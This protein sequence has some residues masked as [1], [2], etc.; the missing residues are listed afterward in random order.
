MTC[1]ISHSPQQAN[2]GKES[3]YSVYPFLVSH[4]SAHSGLPF[5]LTSALKQELL[6]RHPRP[7]SLPAAFKSDPAA[8]GCL[9]LAPVPSAS[10]LP[11]HIPAAICSWLLSTADPQS[12][13]SPDYNTR[14]KSTPTMSMLLAPQPDL[15]T[16]H[17][18]SS[19]HRSSCWMATQLI[20]LRSPAT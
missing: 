10:T 14:H 1:P 12:A 3:P 7:L 17:L 11:A 4:S 5:T 20:P 9:P 13:V 6:I 2:F 16:W 19:T 15:S 8:K 18:L